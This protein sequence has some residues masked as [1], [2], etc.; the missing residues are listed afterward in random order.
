MSYLDL[1]FKSRPAPP[2]QRYSRRPSAKPHLN[3]VIRGL[4]ALATL[5]GA[6]YLI[7][8]FLPDSSAKIEDSNLKQ[9]RL[10]YS[11]LLPKVIESGPQPT[12]IS[13]ITESQDDTRWK[14]SQ[15]KS[16]DT[17]ASIFASA[18]L[19]ASTTYK[20]VNLND[21]TRKLSR[22][23]P[24][25][26]I[27]M[28]L[29]DNEKL[30]SLK[31]MPDIT[32]T[33]HIRRL[34]DDSLSSELLHHPLEP[35]PVFKSGEI[36][37]SLFEAAAESDI[38]E[39]VIM[40]LAGIFGW[41][42]DFA[43]D[44]RKGD[45]FGIVYNELYK[46]GEK[47]RDGKILAAEFINQGKSYQAV[48]YTDPKGESGY[49][50]PEGKSM[51]KAFLRSPVKFSRISSR[52][53]R[54]RWHPVL[55]K[56]RSHKGVDYAAAR[57]TPIRAAGDGKI[58]FKGTKGGYGKS[59]FIQHGNKYTTVYAHMSRYANGVRKGKQVKQ[60]QVIGYVGSTGLASGP[61]LHYEFRV[62][63]VHRNPLTVKLP[64]AE[65][66]DKAYKTHFSREIKTYLSMLNLM[67]KD[68]VAQLQDE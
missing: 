47:I 31:Y 40:E 48:Y 16:G 54:K 2:I 21:Q 30:V 55:S 28:L 25:Q 11:V 36:T 49:F 67:S 45:Q 50:N 53:T 62:N 27:S 5:I 34:E 61:H 1:D 29:D 26:S 44:I 68:T 13:A 22:I 66:I 42:I 18:G 3:R 33:L 32:Q 56:W 17:L 37:S 58:K 20:V 19:S 10:H 38:S 6:V 59:I 4:T 51:R 7:L 14:T 15:I 60:G 41:D 24:G 23:R 39:N 9:Q 46:D 63:G 12:D 43:L 52:F 64:A 8:S 35:I 65:P 57:G